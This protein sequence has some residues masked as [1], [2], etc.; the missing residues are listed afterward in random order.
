MTSIAA[1]VVREKGGPFGIERIELDEPRDDEVL[2]R[3]SGVGLCHT[4][5]VVRDQYFPTPLPAILGHEGS[6]VV[7]KIGRSVTKV[8]PGDH[9]V[10][11]VASC[12]TCANCLSGRG[13]YCNDLYG[14]NFSGRRPDGSTPCHDAHGHEVS[15]YFFAQSSFADHALASERNVVKIAKDVPIELM[16]PLGCGLQTGAGAVINALKPEAGTSIAIFG[17]GSV[18]LAAVM[19]ARVVGCTRIIAVDLNAERLAL[20][21]SLGATDVIDAGAG[22]VVDAIRELTGDGVQYS[23][24][25]TGLPAVARQAVD[26]LRLTGTCGIIGVSPLGTEL[27]LDMNGILFGRSVRGIIE[28][29]SVPDIFIPQ[30]IELWRQDRFPFDRLVQYYPLSR[31]EE[32]AAASER[33]DVLKAILVPGQ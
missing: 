20:A 9:V 19:A 8:A 4:D 16:G 21:R 14:R 11:T 23:L 13:G 31:I 25:C 32:A 7:E 12:G 28:G 24:E 5:L 18:G 2:I 27:T 15:A 22:S 30:L 33:G 6:G 29:D 3:I 1:A 10:L 26:A 17:A